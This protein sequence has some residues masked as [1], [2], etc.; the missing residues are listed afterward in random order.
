M[1]TKEGAGVHTMG[2]SKEGAGQRAGASFREGRR[3]PGNRKQ[4]RTLGWMPS[5]SWKPWKVRTSAMGREEGGTTMGSCREGARL[6]ERRAGKR[7]ACV[8]GAAAMARWR[9]GR[10]GRE[11]RWT[12]DRGE[13]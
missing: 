13:G 8:K 9:S 2:R 3:P 7:V 11:R 6:G 5:R 12:R 4:G 1:A 10:L